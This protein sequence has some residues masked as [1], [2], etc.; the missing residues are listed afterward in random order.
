MK[1]YLALG[2]DYLFV[3]GNKYATT[4]SYTQHIRHADVTT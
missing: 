2:L 1:C 3:L 4:K